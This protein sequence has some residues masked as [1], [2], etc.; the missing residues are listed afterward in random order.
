[1]AFAGSGLAVTVSAFSGLALG[2]AV[3]GLYWRRYLLMETSL[4]TVDLTGSIILGFCTTGCPLVLR[5]MLLS[6]AVG[7]ASFFF[8]FAFTLA[9]TAF[10]CSLSLLFRL[11]ISMDFKMI[12]R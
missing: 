8:S 5:V 3:A 4:W 9:S 11:A 2:T 1:M 12:L 7:F 6:L 10:Y